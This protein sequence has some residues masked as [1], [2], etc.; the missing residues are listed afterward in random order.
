MASRN[1]YAELDAWVQEL[2]GMEP[3]SKRVGD[4]M[5]LDKLLDRLPPGEASRWM[6]EHRDDI[7]RVL[8]PMKRPTGEGR[9]S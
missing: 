4:L 8:I 7:N 3:H 9:R 5:E 1:V 6:D 2:R